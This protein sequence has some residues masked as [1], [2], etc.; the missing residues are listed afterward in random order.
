MKKYIVILVS[1]F[2]VYCLAQ[3]TLNWNAWLD[4]ELS[5]G[6]V[7]SHFYYNQIHKDKTGWRIG[8][9]DINLMAELQ[10]TSDWSIN[11]RGQ[12]DRDQG[13]ALE[14]FR[15]PL[16]NI[17][18]APTHENWSVI[19][20]RFITPF[21][22]FAE[23]QHSK[24]RIFINLPL[25]FAYYINMSP[26][27]GFAQEMGEQLFQIDEQGQWG[28]TLQYY[29]AYSNGLRYD[30][31]IVPDKVDWSV[32][33]TTSSP[34]I[35]TEPFDVNN[36]GLVT[37]LKLQPTY[38]W[39]QRISF[40]HGT[41]LQSSSLE[42]RI[43]QAFTQMLVGT[44]FVIGY[45]FWEL[46]GEAIGAFYDA[47]QYFPN[48]DRFSTYDDES[49]QSIYLSLNLKY[50]PPFLSGLYLAYGI[51]QL[52][53]SE[54]SG[55]GWDNSVLRH[56]VGAGYKITDYLLLRSNYMLQSV[57]NHPMWEQNTWRTTLTI[58]Y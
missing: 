41:F 19:L 42:D 44:D 48:E 55:V 29:G 1:I 2:P 47:P 9:N 56:N 12:L 37:K 43:D 58:Y 16:A 14:Q 28:T 36:W 5:K 50:E 53:F 27:V 33:L 25:S 3:V 17:T 21:A 38:F 6:Q 32:T 20:G 7:N 30:W 13:L 10:L 35:F 11:M 51:E 39:Q 54:L 22:S 52:N 24:D 57:E 18:Y 4:T 34:N 8:V 40:S 23:K 46:T 45:G 31:S 26:K 15:M 49:L